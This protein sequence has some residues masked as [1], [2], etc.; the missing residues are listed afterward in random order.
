MR[1][2]LCLL[3]SAII[4]LLITGC[5]DTNQVSGNALPKVV[6]GSK[7]KYTLLLTIDGGGVKGIVPATILA[8]LESDLNRPIYEM[9]DVI[10]GTSTGGIISVGLTT[11][12]NPSTSTATP[13]R[14]A[15]EIQ[16]IYLNNCNEILFPVPDYDTG[17]FYYADRAKSEGVFKPYP[18]GGI[19]RYLQK[20]TG[21]TYTMKNAHDNMIN[22]PNSRI[23]EVFTTCYVVNGKGGAI[24]KKPKLGENYGPYQ[25]TWSSALVSSNN[26][27]YFVWEAARGT[28]AAPIFFPV[29]HVGGGNYTRSSSQERWVIDGGTVT[30]NPVITGL[31]LIRKKNGNLNNVVAVSLGCGINYFNGGIGITNEAKNKSDNHKSGQEYGFWNTFDWAGENLYNLNGDKAGRGRII[32]LLMYANQFTADSQ[33]ENM[34]STKAIE[35]GIRIQPTLPQNINQSFECSMVSKLQQATINYITTDSVGKKEYAKLK[36]L[37]NTYM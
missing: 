16:N 34:I 17:P 25:F 20:L 12:K 29:A 19:E 4:L 28:S 23:R 36:Q 2:T 8:Q 7:T 5:N 18:A 3:F 31:E 10:G 27:N 14:T 21:A 24:Q 15:S 37:L 32:E 26:E 35:A 6:E 1:S 30:N 22:L 33:F 11:P 9:F 13:P